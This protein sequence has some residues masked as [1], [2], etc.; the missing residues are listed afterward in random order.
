MMR[1]SAVVTYQNLLFLQQNKDEGRTLKD[2]LPQ[3]RSN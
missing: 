3:K 2:P 1:T